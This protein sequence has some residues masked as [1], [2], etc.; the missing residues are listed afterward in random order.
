MSVADRTNPAILHRWVLAATSIS[1]V[2]VLLD[3]S[4]VNVA[5]DRIS[6]S[7]T[8]GIAGLQWVVNAYTLAFASLLLTGGTLGDRWGARNVY[9]AGLI[10]FTLAT[11]GCGVAAGLP[12]LMIARVFQGVGAAMLVPCS[13][14]LINQACPDPEQ[15]ARAVGIWVGCGGVALAAGPLVGGA[16][17]QW[18]DWRSIF[19]VNVPIG[20]AG[21]GMAWRIARDAKPSELRPFDLSGQVSAVVALGALISVL[22]EGRALGWDSPLIVAGIITIVAAGVMFLACEA[23]SSYPMLPLS[24]FKSGIFAGSTFVSMASAFVFYG[25]LFVTSLYYQQV[26]SYAPLRAGIAFL[27]MTAMVAL[28]SVMSSSIVRLWGTRNSMCAAFSLYALG[29]LGMLS[30]GQSSRYLL[31]ILPM[32]AIGFASGFV[33][34]ASTAPAIGAVDEDR[35]GIAAAVLNSARQTGAAL[36]VAIFGTLIAALQP[37]KAGMDAA[38]WSAA[39]VSVAAAMVW[40]LALARD[41]N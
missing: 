21:I 27:P 4:I 40:W 18:F 28:G 35:A 8:T 25:L 34:P 2:I 14:K 7:L 33:S 30:A 37:F 10:V 6:V 24:F 41:R 29:A 3:T 39:V 1:Y 17:I 9:L 13:L 38:L 11:M 16:L 19:F 36:G 20:L 22:I 5:L 23:R 15:R 26:R 32:T 31:A 12:G